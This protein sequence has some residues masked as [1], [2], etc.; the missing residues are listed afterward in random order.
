METSI[1]MTIAVMMAA[2]MMG[3]VMIGAMMIGAVIIGMMI[4]ATISR[5]MM[6]GVMRGIVMIGVMI[7]VVKRGATMR[8]VGVVGV[9]APLPSSSMFATKYARF[10][11]TLLVTVGGT[12]VMVL[13]MRLIIMTRT[14]MLLPI[15][16]T[17]IGKLTQPHG[18]HHWSSKQ[19]Q[20]PRQVQ[21]T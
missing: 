13:M 6:I 15:A 2:R 11:V 8:V 21:W 5:A 4:G 9:T 16:S 12:M 20:R 10:M 3:I 1:I 17:P 7:G 14:Y 19:A 18:P